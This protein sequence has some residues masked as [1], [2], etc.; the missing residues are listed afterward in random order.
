MNILTKKRVKLT[1]S[2]L[3]DFH[4]N[5]AKDGLS[6]LSRQTGLSYGLLYN[7]AHGR[8]KTLSIRDYRIIFNKDPI[9]Q[10]PDRRDGTYFR[11]MVKLW[12]YLNNDQSESGLYQEFFDGKK[13]YKKT[14]YRIFTGEID[15]VERRLEE[16]MEQKFFA[17]GLDRSKVQRWIEDLNAGSRK[18][19]VPYPEIKPVLEFIHQTTGIHP[20]FLLKQSVKR[21]EDGN[22]H[23]VSAE[24]FERVLEIGNE[25]RQYLD[26][27]QT[28]DREKMRDNIL[29]KRPDFIPFYEVED[30]LDFLRDYGGQ[31][32]KKY[33]GRGIG[34]YRKKKIKSIAPWRLTKIDQDC[35]DII[36][37]KTGL[38]LS[39]LPAM[40]M[41]QEVG[42]LLSV[43]KRISIQQVCDTNDVEF[44]ADIIKQIT[45][46]HEQ[47]RNRNQVLVRFDEAARYLKMKQKA[48]D[49]MV[50]NHSGLF[51]KIAVRKEQGWYIPDIY[52]DTLKKV[53]GFSLI[54]GK[55]NFLVSRKKE[56]RPA[57]YVSVS[58]AVVSSGS[59]S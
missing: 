48:F 57:C 29:G 54:K 32:P 13:K 52:L 58:A 55:Y 16:G 53:I 41:K 11:D 21:Y 22:L 6:V 46:G 35:R 27:G 17:Q 31:Y 24:I 38:P 45:L 1:R 15:T 42:K 10:M 3:E 30:K 51:K 9:V 2:V 8:V 18:K 50:A 49:Y 19:R 39:S 43:L 34:Y 36:R 4:R 20:T 40:F 44:E 26:S 37:N 47:Y 59:S 14:D 28:P 23:T 7:I 5:A 33:L 56:G 25:I 12:L